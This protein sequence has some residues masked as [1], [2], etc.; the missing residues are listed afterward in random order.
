MKVQITLAVM[1]ALF[2]GSQAQN[3][4]F[5]EFG[6]CEFSACSVATKACCPFVRLNGSKVGA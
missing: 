5:A 3:N 2:Q 1:A 4:L 6:S